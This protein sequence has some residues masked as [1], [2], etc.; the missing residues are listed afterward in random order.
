M[1]TT[2]SG[3][4]P[5][6]AK[7][8]YT[9]NGM[10]L[11]SSFLWMS[12]LLLSSSWTIQVEASVPVPETEDA[13]VK[14]GEPSSSNSSSSSGNAGGN[15]ET[16]A[17]PKTP[18]PR[19]RFVHKTIIIPH[20]DKKFR[21][22]EDAASTIDQMLV[23]ADGV[24]GWANKGVNPGLYSRKLTETIVSAFSS[25]S[26]SEQDA[27]DL[28]DLVHK[29]NHIAAD[30]HL[31]SATCTVVRLKDAHTL[32]TVNVGDSG[33][34]I[35]RRNVNADT[36]ANADTTDSLEVVYASV[37][38][39]KGF[40][41]PYQLGGQYGDQ[42][43]EPNVTDGPNT[44]ELKDKDVIVVVSDGIIDNMDPHEYHDCIRRYQWSESY[45]SEDNE[46]EHVSVVATAFYAKYK[47]YF[48]DKELVSYS[49][50]ADCIARKAYFLGKDQSHHSPFA[51]SAATYG[52]RFLGGKHDDITVV[53]AQVELAVVDPATGDDVFVLDLEK[54]VDFHKTESIFVYKDSDGPI[55]DPSTLP[56]MESIL[57]GILDGVDP[58]GND[59]L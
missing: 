29:S 55:E 58:A 51:R 6:N 52:K 26:P 38:G 8:P 46:H 42:V 22:G 17:T 16:A 20:D 11:F 34:S 9:Y 44:H 50:V 3:R 15:A 56:S 28:K 12:L 36:D 57:Q 23:V 39:Q 19:A 45:F 24:G 59:E 40:N 41:F 32:E 4:K 53:V 47:G 37:P 10:L 30:A 43:Y 35:H 1:M 25:M 14:E 7:R 27:V 33:Y 49:A 13:V 48:D 31:G 5:S 54:D 21:A 18:L 2:T